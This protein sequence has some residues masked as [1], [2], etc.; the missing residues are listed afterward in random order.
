MPVETL[1]Y[2][3]TSRAE[4]SRIASQ[5][6]IEGR[7]EDLIDDDQALL[8]IMEEA[9]DWVNQYVAMIYNESDLANSRWVRSRATWYACYLLTQRLGNPPLFADRIDQYTEDLKSAMAQRIQIPRLPVRSGMVPA[10]SNVIVDDRYNIHKLRVHQSI[11][12]GGTSGRQDPSYLPFG[13]LP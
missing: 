4:M 1:T 6:G 10:M 7:L 5:A 13:D 8:E 3:Y 11:S 9:T 2:V 12:P